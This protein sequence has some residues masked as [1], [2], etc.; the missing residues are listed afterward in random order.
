M[1]TG[2]KSADLCLIEYNMMTPFF[3]FSRFV[4]EFNRVKA[5]SDGGDSDTVGDSSQGQLKKTD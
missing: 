1:S 3:L 2:E 4:Y 5:S